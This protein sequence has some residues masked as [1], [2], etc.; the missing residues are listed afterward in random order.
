MIPSTARVASTTTT[1]V[2]RVSYAFRRGFSWRK[3][4][5]IGRQALQPSPSTPPSPP[6]LLKALEKLHSSHRSE[7]AALN[8][9]LSTLSTQ[10]RSLESRISHLE[11][12]VSHHASLDTRVHRIEH[13]IGEQRKELAGNVALSM[14]MVTRLI[15][16]VREVERWRER[17]EVVERERER[18]ERDRER[19]QMDRERAER[20]REQVQVEVKMIGPDQPQNQNE[21]AAEKYAAASQVDGQDAVELQAAVQPPTAPTA[22]TPTA[23]PQPPF[24]LPFPLGPQAHWHH[25]GFP[26]LEAAELFLQD[27]PKALSYIA[28]APEIAMNSTA[29]HVIDLYS[30]IKDEEERKVLERVFRVVFG[31]GIEDW[32]NATI[33]ERERSVSD[34]AYAFVWRMVVGREEKGEEGK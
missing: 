24:P 28:P 13:G 29:Q 34:A 16:R 4:V 27:L 22:P 3:W 30:S 21:K 2:S 15:E 10:L 8:T 14:E 1:K 6:H 11:S 19:E 20:E 23:P 33:E 9:T 17:G 12:T 32:G 31:R 26:S 5:K 18:L 7:T 25:A